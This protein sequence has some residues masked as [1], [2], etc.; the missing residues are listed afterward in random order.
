MKQTIP[1]TEV[2]PEQ[3]EAGTRAKGDAVREMFSDIAPTYDTLNSLLSAGIDRRW[4]NAA[5][6]EAVANHGATPHVLDVATGTGQ[7]AMTM[8]TLAPGATVTATDFS[9]EM[10][11][12]AA[13]T[14]DARAL[15]IAFSVADGTALPFPDASFDAVT[16]AYALRNFAD[17]DAGIAQ[18]F[19]VLKPGGTLVILDFPPPPKGLIGGLFRLYFERILPFVG[20]MISGNFKA[21]SYLP[22]SVHAFLAPSELSERITEAGFV[23]AHHTLQTFGISAMVVGT[24]PGAET[25]ERNE[26]NQQ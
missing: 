2:F 18:F 17:P 11:K 12:V 3:A 24:K 23:H 5:A 10:L 25:G 16:I 15:D 26:N 8:K 14:A 9:E 19:R 22:R 1:A 4:R 13:R 6:R 20:G 21:Y 7:L